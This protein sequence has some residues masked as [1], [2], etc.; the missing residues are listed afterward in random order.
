[1]SEAHWSKSPYESYFDLVRQVAE[2]WCIELACRNARLVGDQSRRQRW[3]EEY[4]P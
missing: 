1:M 2:Q 4:R 3:A